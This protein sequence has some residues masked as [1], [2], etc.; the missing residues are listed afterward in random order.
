[1]TD[2]DKDLLSFGEN[3]LSDTPNAKVAPTNEVVVAEAK[4]VEAPIVPETKVEESVEFVITD[5]TEV[6]QNNVA[7]VK[8]EAPVID[9][10]KQYQEKVAQ[11]LGLDLGTVKAKL[12][13]VAELEAKANANTYKSEQGKIFDELVSKGIPIETIAS[14]AFKDLKDAGSLQILDYQL[15]LK[16]PNSTAEQR[17]AYLEETYKQS[18]EYLDREKLSGTF[19][20]EQD[21]QLARKELDSLKISALQSP[22]EKQQAEYQAQESQRVSAWEAGLSKKAIDSFNGLE[23]KVKLNFSFDGKPIDREATV[24]VPVTAKDKAEMEAL[25]SANIPYWQNAT[26]DAKGQEFIKDILHNHFVVNNLD[27]IVQGAVNNALSFAAEQQKNYLHS[28]QAPKNNAS[29]ASSATAGNKSDQ[30]TLAEIE[31]FLNN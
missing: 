14:I 21:A 11:D 13:Q 8:A 12:A 17:Q 22:V 9:F 28:Y 2:E 24:K 18:D 23:R 4:V 19:R 20:M 31:A 15:Q 29:A 7:E 6:A 25:V 5:T 1:M 3:L 27:R 16:N 30:Q 10:E 26:A